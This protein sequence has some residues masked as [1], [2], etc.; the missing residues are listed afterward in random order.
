MNLDELRKAA[1]NRNIKRCELLL[2]FIELAK[3]ETELAL[4]HYVI[5]KLKE[6]K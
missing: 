6:V 3:F 1:H 4:G 5:V 2:A